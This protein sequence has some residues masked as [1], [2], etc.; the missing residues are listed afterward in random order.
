MPTRAAVR[1]AVLALLVSP[2]AAQDRQPDPQLPRFR[3]GANLVSVDAYISKD[4]VAITDL[5]PE[6]LEVLEDDK[7]QAIEHFRLVRARAPGAAT[8]A[9]PLGSQAQKAALSD[10]DSRV[11]VLFLDQWHVSRDGAARAKEP[12]SVLLD[13]VIGPD[14]LI[15]LM[16]PDLNPQSLNLTRRGSAIARALGQNW[17]WG[18]RDQPNTSDP[19]ENELM[20]CYPDG[21]PKTPQ[22]NGIAKELIERRREQKTLQSLNALVSHMGTL[23]DERKFVVLLTEGWVQFR[24]NDRLGGVLEGGG[25]PGKP[26]IGV[27]TDGRVFAGSDP[28][29]VAGGF[30]SCERERVMLSFVDHD[31]EIRQLAQKANRANVTFYIIDPRGLAVFDDQINSP[32]RPATPVAD[33]RRLTLRQDGVRELAEQTDGAVVLNTNDLRGGT[34]RMLGNLGSYYLLSYYSTNTRLDGRFR[35]ITVRVKRDG[36]EVRA[37]PGYLAPTEAEARLMGAT[38]VREP[39]SKAPNVLPEAVSKALN[40]IAPA[41]GNLPVRIQAAGG[42]GS[43]RAVVELDPATLKRPEWAGGGTVALRIDPEKGTSAASQEV[44]ATFEPGQRSVTIIAA[45]TVMPPGAYTLRA[46]VTP[47][48]GRLPVRASTVATVPPDAAEVGSGLLALRRGP[49]TGLAYVPTADPRFRRTERLRVEIPLAGADHTGAARLL[50]REG[51]PM[52]LVATYTTRPDEPR[53]VTLGVVDIV[54]APLAAGEY[55]LEL[56]LTKGQATEVVAYGF[57]IVP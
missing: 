30:D 46:E 37:R 43:I 48:G 12:V 50:T 52:P 6:D 15:G 51:Q 3:S 24:R 4:G 19:R 2:T 55:V 40:A 29:Q 42:R 5:R 47:K 53:Q 45:D 7:P 38:P 44:T 49:S 11:W 17:T 20:A 9:E 21:N 23:R 36:A 31:F 8:R 27:G 25:I 16:T 32:L 14:D 18:E 35:R 34:E 56:T 33:Q 54:L 13:K 57:R 41:R 22:L 28:T 10:P 39:G 26:Q 1:F